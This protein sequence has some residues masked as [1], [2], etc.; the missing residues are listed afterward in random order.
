M[1]AWLSAH[2]RACT[3]AFARLVRAP[4]GSLLS[5]AAIGTAL[6]LPLALHLALEQLSGL[7]AHVA[8]GPTLSV[9]LSVDAGGDAVRAMEQRLR[10]HAQVSG[11][12]YV[13]RDAALAALERSA[14]VHD[15]RG[16]LGG[17]PLPDAFIVTARAPD[18]VEVLREDLARW[19]GVEH[20][21]AD[22]QWAQ[23]LDTLLR[24]GRT[25]VLLGTV[26]LAVLLLAVTFSTVRLQILARRDEIEVARLIGA[27][28]AFVRRP[29]LWFGLLQGLL[30]GA[31]AAAV[32]GAAL[33]LIDR[34]VRSLAL[35]YGAGFGLTGPGFRDA[36]A[37][38][39]AAAGLTTLGA[40]LS[41][42]KQLTELEKNT[43]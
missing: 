8:R 7:A 36:A 11:V 9:F 41:T 14:G 37:A 15:V 32:A 35:L 30:G 3:D 6:S 29:F 21:Q 12:E 13:P 33:W 28:T 23:R 39:G 10:G 18:A 25:L 4:L 1:R 42:S 27:T 31:L 5:I 20:V 19:A 40:W 17:N 22:A 2:L 34:E 26:L 16:T 24:L 38:I 43:R